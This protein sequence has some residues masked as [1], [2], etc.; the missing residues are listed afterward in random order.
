[1]KTSK[2][3][4][5]RVLVVG[6][7]PAGLAATTKLGEIGIP[8][9]LVDPDPD[10][11][12]KLA[13]EEW[14]FESGVS[15]NYAMR[16]G[17]LRILRNP[18]IRC[19][20]PG[21]ISSLKH[22]PQGFT[23]HFSGHEI[24]ID[25][26]QCILCGRCAEVCPAN[27]P[28][29]N[30]PIKPFTRQS[31]PGRPVIEKRR[32]PLC[33]ANCPL[34]VNVQGYLALT[35]AGA[36]EE[37]LELIRKE[38]V[39]PGICGR[40]CT[41]PCE[42]AC[43]RTQY[44]GPL[45][46]KDIKRFV[47]DYERANKLHPKIDLCEKRPQKVAVIGSGPAGLA[48]AAD[49]ARF[50]YP[51]T[52]FEKEN[53]PGGL[54]RYG[55]GPYR[56]PRDILDYEIEYI[57]RL[58]VEIRTGSGIDLT[59][60]LDTLSTS[61]SAVII[62]TGT[63]NDRKL[64][65]PGED[66]EGVEGCLQF[67]NSLY[68]NQVKETKQKVAVIGDGNA[69]FDAARSLVRLGASVTIVS[70]FPKE[71]IPA[72]PEE[73]KAAEI[74]GITIVPSAQ[75]V[76][77]IGEQGRLRTVRCMPTVP[78]TPDDK[79]IPWPVIV[80][81]REPFDLDFERAIV[82]IGQIGGFSKT[83]EEYPFRVTDRGFI[84]VDENLRTSMPRVY[85]AGDAVCGP[86]SVVDAMASGRNAARAVHF[87]LSGE[88]HVGHPSQ[89][90]SYKDFVDIP[91]NLPVV[92]RTSM[93]ERPLSCRGNLT[94][95]VALGFSSEQAALEASRC[96]QCGSCAECFKCVEA[97]GTQNAVRHINIAEKSVE[98]AGVVI[99]AHPD[100]V[101]PIKGED[102]VRAYSSKSSKSDVS[103]MLV[104]GFAAAAEA[105]LL[106]GGN[107]QRLKGHGLS[108]TPP[109][110]QLSTEIR[111]GVFACRCNDSLGWSDQFE[112]YLN[113]LLNHRY[114]V[115]S[116][117]IGSA[118]TP[119]GYGKILRTI[120]ENGLTRAVLAS[121]VCCPLNFICSACTDQ[122]TRLKSAL[123]NATGISR[124]MVETCNLRG[125][126]LRFLPEDPQIAFERFKGLLDRSVGRARLLKSMPSPARHYNFTT[127][128]IGDCE[129]SL[130]SASALADAG[131][132]VFLFG[133]PEKPL[134]EPL[135]HPNIHNF[136]HSVTRNLRGTVGNF[137]LTVDVSGNEQEFQVGAVILG[138]YSRKRIPYLPM[139]DWRPRTIE[140]DMQKRGR[141][142]VPFF[143]PGSTTV[144][145]LFLSNPPG[146]AASDRIK[147]TAA[148]I[149]AAS[150]MP[151][152]PRQSK[153]F[154]VAVDAERCRGCG[155]CA[156]VCPY[157]A[158]SFSTNGVGG[159]HAVVDE[160]ICKGCGNCIAVCPSGAADSP[161][162]DRRYLE[163]MID[164][165]LR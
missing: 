49:L 51:V 161:Y 88:K 138:E 109:D 18:N 89:R 92:A 160:A 9:T 55:I 91:P 141:T 44:D 153:G 156:E 61:Y 122:R 65:I 17:L 8:V 10:L 126:A 56:L 7:N 64:G 39:L 152:G 35:R 30:R 96:L 73:I 28:D 41:H 85:G 131:M 162:R 86:R 25:P 47:A 136:V 48:A 24:Y 127:A 76:S 116:E 123:F 77:F 34:G 83:G 36:F 70:W 29:G 120:R 11:D 146:I 159:W 151:R 31:L 121:C 45:A 137:H 14:R 13:R 148:A 90:P 135:L 72:Q 102:V 101:P 54:L 115:V 63:W 114:V 106:L 43:R 163:Q 21:Q 38:N 3:R 104:R 71:L 33:Q 15:L 37:A 50:G 143:M 58:G 124:A 69:A 99:I 118:C 2:D 27:G 5:Y 147:G 112:T 150:V 68:R 20:I 140:A 62:A 1:M 19:V 157:Q 165:V 125:E 67:L 53:E 75:A 74:E 78:G 133:A 142:G 79:G 46:I 105:M 82:A 84:H 57:Q 12:S 145:G 155:R 144:P 128:V 60:Q 134:T 32:Q 22:T 59:T 95:E 111:I 117:S 87:D 100:L 6:A 113:S 42:L 119:D 80:P 110:P 108:F 149:Q 103:G 52:V 23:A 93:P 26:E 98:H 130:K 164:H 154:T 94:D 16:P 66:L 129:A 107:A 132:D 139:A 4:L 40:V 81:D 97:C 158:V